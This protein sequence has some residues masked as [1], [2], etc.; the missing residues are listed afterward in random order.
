[1]EFVNI[2]G[3]NTI[4]VIT[5]EKLIQQTVSLIL[6][7]GYHG[8]GINE[9]LRA[10][11]VTKGSLY[12]HFPKG[13]D[14]LVT[15]ALKSSTI[16]LSLQY[17]Q[18]LKSADSL[19]DGLKKLI[20]HAIQELELSE[21]KA[22]SILINVSQE[23][24]SI[25]KHL[26]TTCKQLFELIINNLESFFLEYDIEKWEELARSFFTSFQGAI[27]LSKAYQETSFLAQLRTSILPEKYL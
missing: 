7:K 9:I 26:Q 6:E 14:Q 21:Y 2:N 23:L 27:V 10:S 15:E 22:G 24:G 19:E 25:N 12:H 16:K 5:K 11:Q 18:L 17:K 3:L 20:N 13:K 8:T 1:V 4:E